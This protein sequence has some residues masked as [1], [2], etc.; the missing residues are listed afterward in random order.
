MTTETRTPEEPRGD[1]EIYEEEVD[2]ISPPP[3]ASWGAIF[4]GTAIALTVALVIGLLGGAIGLGTFDPAAETKPLSGFGVWTGI[5][6]LLEIVVALFA[7]GWVAGRLANKPRGLDGVLNSAVVWALTTLLV[8]VG[9]GALTSTVVSTAASALKEGVSAAGSAVGGVIEQTDIEMQRG[10]TLSSIKQEARR[11]L[12]QTQKEELQPEDLRQEAQAL[13]QLAI[14]TSRD[15]ATAPQ[16][17]GQ[18]VEQAIDRVFRQLDGTVE[19]ADKEA[20]VNILVARTDYDRQ[21]ARQVVDNWTSTFEQALGGIEQVGQD[22]AGTAKTVA[23]D[24]TDMAATMMWW[25][26]LGI[27][28]GLIAACA[29]GYLGSPKLRVWHERR[30]RAARVYRHRGR[31]SSPRL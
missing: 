14:E 18:I 1:D 16:Q 29:G 20:L 22:I 28:L 10:Q 12:E 9:F 31:G 30:R 24:V 2:T 17:T 23:G 21:K 7:G 11:L 6:V 25:S 15:V 26:L 19:A 3:R 13:E 8:V 27:V 5:W 4:A